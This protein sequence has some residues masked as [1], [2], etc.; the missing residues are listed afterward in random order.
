MNKRYINEIYVTRALAIMG[1]LIVH[2][3]SFPVSQYDPNTFT[4]EAYSFLNTFFR[5]GTP[6]FIFL[7]S[8]V[9][10]YSYYHRPLTSQLILGFYKKRLLYIILPYIIFS[11]IYFMYNYEYYSSVFTTR[12]LVSTFFNQ[13]LTGSTASHLYFVFISIQFYLLFP[14]LLFAFKKWPGLVKYSI[15]LG[16]VIQWAFVFLNHQYGLIMNKGIVSL[17]YFSYYF[18]GIYLGVNF[19][20]FSNFFSFEFKWKE[21]LLSGFIWII[22]AIFSIAHALIWVWTRTTGQWAEN[23]VYEALW[24]GHTFFSALVLLQASFYIYKNWSTKLNNVLI[25]LGVVSFGVYLIHLLILNLYQKYVPMPGDSL[26]YHLKSFGG[27]IIVLALSWLI[28]GIVTRYKY[29]WILF[30]ATPKKIPYKEKE[31]H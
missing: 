18:F 6:T 13:L 4:F 19:D 3:T 5:F 14:L 17:S 23:L 28:V 29:S 27:F 15:I 7:S 25:H 31:K 26:L 1:V 21:K 20:K 2:A 24:N 8:F 9:L 16:F 11:V 12:E 10:F 22:W 30:G